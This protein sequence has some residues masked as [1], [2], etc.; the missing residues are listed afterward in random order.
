MSDK[1]RKPFPYVAGAMIDDSIMGLSKVVHLLRPLLD[2]QQMT[3]EEHYRRVG[4][5]VLETQQAIA[6]L[7]EVRQM[8]NDEHPN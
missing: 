7:T 8:R 4:L 3:I 5:A 6:K 1:R 2:G